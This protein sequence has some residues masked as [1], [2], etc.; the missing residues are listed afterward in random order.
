MS[1]QQACLLRHT[2][3]LWY[4]YTQVS[5]KQIAAPDPL[6]ALMAGNVKCVEFNGSQ[7]GEVL[8]VSS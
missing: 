2:C 5:L 1:C 6:E 8:C 4:G 7:V 3:S